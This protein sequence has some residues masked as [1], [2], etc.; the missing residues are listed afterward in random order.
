[1]KMTQIPFDHIHHDRDVR[2]MWPIVHRVPIKSQLELWYHDREMVVKNI[3]SM[4]GHAPFA[5][6]TQKAM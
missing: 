2:G 1:M 3:H 4:Q 5:S 6:S